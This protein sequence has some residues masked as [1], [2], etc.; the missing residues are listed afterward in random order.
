VRVFRK[1]AGEEHADRI[2]NLILADG[3]H[4]GDHPDFA[5]VFMGIGKQYQEAGL[6]GEKTGGG[7]FRKSPEQALQEIAKLESHKALHDDNHPEHQIIQDRITELYK[8][9]HPEQKSEVL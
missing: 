9:A 7:G 4:L 2:S 6:H 5:R 8:D 1:A 3:T